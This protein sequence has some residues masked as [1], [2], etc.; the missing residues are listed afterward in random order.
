MTLPTFDDLKSQFNGPAKIGAL[1]Q[2]LDEYLSAVEQKYGPRD[3]H[4][5]LIIEFYDG[6]PYVHLGAGIRWIKL[7]RDAEVSV[8]HA[9]LLPCFCNV[10]T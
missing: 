6:N 9:V 10:S 4:N 3:T 8:N 5:A 2:L 1:N 7:S